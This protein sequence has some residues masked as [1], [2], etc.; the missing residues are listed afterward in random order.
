MGR[1]LQ[2]DFHCIFVWRNF[3]CKH[4]FLLYS[5]KGIALESCPEMMYIGMQD[6]FFTFNMFDAQ[7]RTLLCICTCIECFF[8]QVFA[9]TWQKLIFC[10]NLALGDLVFH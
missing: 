6:Q 9:H 7:V 3:D 8:P 5:Y 1:I 10:R 4:S 2:C